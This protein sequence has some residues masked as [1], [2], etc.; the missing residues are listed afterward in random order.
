MERLAPPTVVHGE[1]G[2][3]ALLMERMDEADDGVFLSALRIE[4]W[5]DSWFT[6]D[7]LPP[8]DAD[9]MVAD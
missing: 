7:E 5:V 4:E 9:L 8:P 2:E 1:K 3:V 6:A